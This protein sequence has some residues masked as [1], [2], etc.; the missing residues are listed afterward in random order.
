M[1]KVTFFFREI[2]CIAPLIDYIESNMIRGFLYVIEYENKQ[3]ARS[4]RRSFFND[5]KQLN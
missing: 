2:V 5:K 1:G 4:V 3:S